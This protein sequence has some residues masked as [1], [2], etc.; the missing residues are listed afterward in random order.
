MRISVILAHPS[1]ESF[2]AAIAAAAVSALKRNGHRVCFH[3]LYRE[4]FD[5]VLPAREIPKGSR[6]PA[7]IGKHCAEIVRADGLVLVHPNWWGEPPA[8]LKGWVDR[9]LRAGVAYDFP[10]GPEGAAGLPIKL[11]KI[12]T[13]LVLNT[14]DTAAARER[15][16]LGDP[17]QRLWTNTLRY[18]GVRSVRRTMYRII[19]TSTLRQR[20]AWL[21]DTRARV[22][23][24]FPPDKKSR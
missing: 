23:A 16:V 12:K 8:I 1:A 5:P 21:A 3:D 19:V 9:V 10:D 2:N 4:R 13:A 22:S 17:L 18:C 7:L 24:L 11:L 6:L 20:A 14:S 15:R